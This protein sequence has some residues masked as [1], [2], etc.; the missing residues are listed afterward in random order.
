MAAATPPEASLFVG[1]L[2]WDT[3]DEGLNAHL[4][5][6]GVR[7]HACEIQFLNNGR[8]K[9][10]GL[11]TVDPADADEAISMIEGTDLDGR[12]LL[13]RADRGPAKKSQSRSQEP[14]PPSSKLFVGN[15]N[16]DTTE[17]TASLSLSPS[18]P[19]SANLL[20]P[21]SRIQSSTNLPG[22]GDLSEVRLPRGSADGPWEVLHHHDLRGRGLGRSGDGRQRGGRVANSS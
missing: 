21:V 3:D 13:C 8:S 14:P 18:M 12:T 9:G 7:L 17:S 20:S 19:P 16:F 10:W 22:S 6:L 4:V 15:L 11:V 1:N 2:S 5:G